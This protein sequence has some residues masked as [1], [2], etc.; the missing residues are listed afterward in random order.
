MSRFAVY[1]DPPGCPELL[2]MVFIAFIAFMAFMAGIAAALSVQGELYLP[3][4]VEGL[5]PHLIMKSKL[6][7]HN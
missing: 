4:K 5:E 2:F 6:I 3:F 1:H 7:H